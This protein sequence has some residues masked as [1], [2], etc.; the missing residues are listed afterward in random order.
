MI[1]K[2]MQIQEVFIIDW[3]AIPMNQ[4]PR[5]IQS[6]QRNRAPTLYFPVWVKSLD[7]SS[8]YFFHPLV[9]CTI[10]CHESLSPV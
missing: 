1:Q 4:I 3:D 10:Y 8:Y 2:I 7:R 6:S 5:Y 9:T